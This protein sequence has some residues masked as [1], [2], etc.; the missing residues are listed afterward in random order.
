M[1]THPFHP[2]LGRELVVLFERHTRRGLWFVCEVDGQRR[3]TLRQEWTDRGVLAAEQRLAVEG[4][5][6]LREVIDAV[7]GRR[8]STTQAGE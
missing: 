8:S 7:L 1:V 4:L 6:A 3:V 5:G 2:L